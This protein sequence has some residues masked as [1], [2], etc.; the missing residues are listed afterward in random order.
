M[1]AQTTC[2]S[3]PNA[4]SLLAELRVKMAERIQ[5]A[6]SARDLRISACQYGGLRRAR[7]IAVGVCTLAVPHVLHAQSPHVVQGGAVDVLARVK[8][9]AQQVHRQPSGEGLPCSGVP[10]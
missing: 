10:C 1:V 3:H 9:R 7:M 4:Q 2:A 8:H 5:C 6:L